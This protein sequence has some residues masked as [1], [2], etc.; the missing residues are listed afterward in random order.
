MT[1]RPGL[2]ALPLHAALIVVVIVS[3]FPFFVMI[4]GGLKTSGE[5]ASNAAGIPQRPTLENY[6]NLMTYNAGVIVRTYANSLFIATTYTVLTLFMATL[7]AYAFAKMH[8]RG[9]DLIFFLLLTTMMIPA[10]LNMTPLYLMFSR[11]HW[12]NTYQVQIIPGTANVF[13]LFLLKQYVETIPD[14]LLEAARID[15]AGHLRIY[16]DVIVPTAMPA[17]GALSILV[18]LGKWND[19]LFP[20]IMIDKPNMMPIMEILPTLSVKGS[21]L[22]IPTELILAGCTVVVLPLLIVFFAFQEK[23]MASVTLG[24][25]KG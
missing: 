7:A 10:E 4:A 15:G 5:M 23:F 11:M 9:R 16:W 14:S 18:F 12:L 13:A 6:H 3:V 22:A 21:E 8:F 25:V 20:K 17:I 19:Y 1:S 24:A 2:K